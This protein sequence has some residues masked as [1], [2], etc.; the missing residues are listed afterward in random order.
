MLDWN[1]I[2]VNRLHMDDLLREAEMER[3]A[4]SARTQG[5]NTL[6]RALAWLGD[7]L[8]AWGTAMQ[9]RHARPASSHGLVT[10]QLSR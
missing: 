3:L 10:V 2:A 4:Q 5:T 9:T 1:L 7:R 6:S 8:V